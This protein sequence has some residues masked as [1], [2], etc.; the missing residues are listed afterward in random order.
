MLID[1]KREQMYAR[2]LENK[3]I[4]DKKL[5]IAKAALLLPPML[6][7][8]VNVVEMIIQLFTATLFTFTGAAAQG[9]DIGSADVTWL[10]NIVF[11]L[12][13]TIFAACLTIFRTGLALK[14]Y[15]AIY[16]GLCIL[17]VLA[18][19]AFKAYG[20]GFIPLCCIFSLPVALWNAK[21]TEE[22]VE[23]SK[24]EGYPHF[25]PTLM[26]DREREIIKASKEEIEEMSPE[27]RIMMERDGRI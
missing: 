15:K 25:N 17:S 21:L 24:L 14:Y 10:I 20:A 12:P 7:L 19:F 26:R 1:K 5:S 4:L 18:I 13:L 8:A 22:D 16:C 11:C 6:V 27:D 2:C 9:A 23:M 3:R